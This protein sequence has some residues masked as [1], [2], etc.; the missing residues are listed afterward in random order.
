MNVGDQL[1][2]IVED[3]LGDDARRALIAYHR[4]VG[5]E[6]PWI[7]Q[8][9]V[10]LARRDG[11]SWAR[12]GRLLGR[13]RQAVQKRFEGLAPIRRANPRAEQRRQEAAFARLLRGVMS[14]PDPVPW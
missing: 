14:E 7:E 2:I 12:I 3:L 13:S 8:R 5:D 11:W 9:V 10:G 1:H 4:L 6:L